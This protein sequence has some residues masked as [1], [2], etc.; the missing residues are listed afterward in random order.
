M[1]LWELSSG[2]EIRS[3]EGAWP[4]ESCLA[5]VQFSPDGRFV[6]ASADRGMSLWSVSSGQEICRFYSFSDGEWVAV[7]HEGFYNASSGGHKYLSARSGDN[8]Q[9]VEPHKEQ[10]FRPDVVQ[11]ILETPRNKRRSETIA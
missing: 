10:W 9:A 2:K 7:T 6:L 8:I 4:R 1:K 5:S 3:F 11:A